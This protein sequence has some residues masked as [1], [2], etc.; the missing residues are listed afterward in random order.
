[1]TETYNSLP[2]PGPNQAY[3]KVSA[4]EAGL[5][6]LDTQ[7]FVEGSPPNL[8]WSPSLS[9][10]LHH[11][12][13]NATFVFDLGIRAEQET[14]PP[15][16]RAGI[17]AVFPVTV[18]QDA[19]ASL[20][21]GGLFP[22]DVDAVAISHAHWDHTGDPRPFTRATFLLGG[23]AEALFT[24][25]YPADAASPFASDLLPRERTKFLSP[26]GWAPLGPFPRALD[27]YGDGSLYVVDAPGHLPGHINL[28]ART[29]GDGAW[30]YLAGDSAHHWSLVTG[31]GRIA[32]GYLGDPHA[33]MHLDRAQSEANLA[34][35]RA[36]W[37][38]PR[39]RVL[40]AHDEPWYKENKGESAF[41]PGFIESL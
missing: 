32:V 7:I 24:P 25:G 14:Y 38:T 29:S 8:V 4:L 26:D 5:I 23:D 11:S 19:A 1:M 6:G 41:W 22:A 31:E 36:L 33:C 40:L 30:I 12:A 20:G 21:K 15:A 27:Y 13:T 10:L 35:I 37:K 9:F 28:L 39:V 3:C 34:R 16:V 18:E 2:P 17:K